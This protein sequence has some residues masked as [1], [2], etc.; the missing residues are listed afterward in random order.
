MQRIVIEARPDGLV[1]RAKRWEEEENEEDEE[2]RSVLVRLVGG[3]GCNGVSPA[4]GVLA[5]RWE[6]EENKEEE[7]FS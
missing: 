3:N 1:V 5:N 7:T 4:L 2:G 6:Q